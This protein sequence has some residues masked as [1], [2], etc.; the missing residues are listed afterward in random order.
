MIGRPACGKRTFVQRLCLRNRGGHCLDLRELR[1]GRVERLEPPNN[2]K[3]PGTTRNAASEPNR[4]Y[5]SIAQ[6]G[7]GLETPFRDLAISAFA[8]QRPGRD[9]REVRLLQKA[10]VWE[11]QSGDLGALES[12]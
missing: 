9:G 7:L 1:S 4:P 3:S 12:T 5:E 11:G 2:S 6:F 8:L 10:R